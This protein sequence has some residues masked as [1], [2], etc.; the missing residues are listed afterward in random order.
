[1]ESYAIFTSHKNGNGKFILYT[2]KNG[3]DWMVQ[4]TVL[5]TFI[6]I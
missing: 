1:M 4:M 5:P 3:D 6:A 2:Y